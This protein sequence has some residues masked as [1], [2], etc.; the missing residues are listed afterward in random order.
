MFLK[1]CL[2]SLKVSCSHTLVKISSVLFISYFI[3]NFLMATRAPSEYV[4]SLDMCNYFQY[5]NIISSKPI[6]ISV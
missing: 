2:V 1:S 6:F 3:N 4:L 5:I